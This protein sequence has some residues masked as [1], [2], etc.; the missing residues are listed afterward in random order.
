MATVNNSRGDDG[1]VGRLLARRNPV[2]SKSCANGGNNFYPKLPTPFDIHYGSVVV[3]T[4]WPL[5]FLENEQGKCTIT[6][7]VTPQGK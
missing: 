6:V 7:I 3:R 4:L 1:I 5:L 2:A